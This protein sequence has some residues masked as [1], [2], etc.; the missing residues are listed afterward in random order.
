MRTACKEGVVGSRVALEREESMRW[1][2]NDRYIALVNNLAAAG[3]P[4]ACFVLGLTLVFAQRCTAPAGTEWLRRAAAAGHKVAAYVLGVLHYSYRDK[5]EAE[6]YIRQVEG[7]DEGVAH[8][9]KK[10][11]SGRTNRKCVRCRAQAVQAVREVTWK[12]DGMM[13]TVP[14]SLLPPAEDGGQ[15]CKGSGCSVPEGWAGGCV[16]F[17]SDGCRIRHEYSEFFSQVSLPVT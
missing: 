11:A 15:G 6:R 5:Q 10:L 9:C 2:D 16:V 13:G 3:N 8:G 7:E 17:C 14:V 1:F 4:E 12:V